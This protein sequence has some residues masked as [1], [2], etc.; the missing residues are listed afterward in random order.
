[1]ETP[2]DTEAVLAS[3]KELAAERH[4]KIPQILEDYL[5]HVARTGN[6][7]FENEWDD[8]KRLL[9]LKLDCNIDYFQHFCSDLPTDKDFSLHQARTFLYDRFDI[10]NR[11]PFTI[12]RLVEVLTTSRRQYRRIDKY[13]RAIEKNLMV[14][15]TVGQE[16]EFHCETKFVPHHFNYASPTVSKVGQ[17]DLIPLQ[18]AAMDFEVRTRISMRIFNPALNLM[19]G[20]ESDDEDEDEDMDDDSDTPMV[21]PALAGASSMDTSNASGSTVVMKNGLRK[22]KFRPHVELNDS[23]PASSSSS[24]DA[25]DS[26][27]GPVQ[28]QPV[29]MEISSAVVEAEAKI[30]ETELAPVKVEETV[31]VVEMEDSK[32][33]IVEETEAEV[34]PLEPES[35]LTV[36]AAQE[37]MIPVP[38]KEVE[39]EE[40]SLESFEESKAEEP[41]QKTDS[42]EKEIESSDLCP[43][44]EEIIKPSTGAT[45]NEDL[46][47]PAPDKLDGAGDSE[48]KEEVAEPVTCETAAV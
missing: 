8:V 17:A 10:F 1:M 22:R 24:S 3:L 21:H 25:S 9:K 31:S 13:L 7:V 5:L 12:Q 23:P 42:E 33:M 16:T 36:A 20:D 46:E 48:T 32:P 26:D 41:L 15:S 40:K 4:Q 2:L 29:A 44:P 37:E 18:N 6:V 45:E 14:V 43:E 11:P 19:N 47:K 27:P 38:P 34:K 39:V 28:G 30:K 35:Q